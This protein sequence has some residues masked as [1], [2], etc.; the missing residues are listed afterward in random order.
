MYPLM[1]GY[2]SVAM[3][4]DGEVGGNDQTFNMLAGRTLLKTIKNKEKFV[5][6]TKLL[7]D[8]NGK[9]MGKTE[10]NMLALSDTA[11]DMIGK[12]MSWTDGM[13]IPAF[14][15]CTNEPMEKISG[16]AR[17]VT[18]SAINPRDL[19]MMLAKKIVSMYFSDK[20]ADHAEMLFDSKFQKKEIPDE[21]PEAKFTKDTLLVDV[22]MKENFI[23]SKG[24]FA[25]L[26]KENAI[27]NLID[28]KKITD[29]KYVSEKAVYKIGKKRFIKIV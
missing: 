10:G 24:E 29:I 6:T 9:K 11:E 3:N 8:S 16:Y 26:V 1:Q 28:N 21:V 2:D 23:T 12:V 14:E 27:T 4:V 5:L 19:K 17:D 20:I 15:L 22:L 25:R 13:T 18:I 7:E